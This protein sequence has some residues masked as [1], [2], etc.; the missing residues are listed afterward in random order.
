MSMMMWKS[1]EPCGDVF[2]EAAEIDLPA[3][4]VAGELRRGPT[5]S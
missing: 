1:S 4:S 3:G 2:E 5:G